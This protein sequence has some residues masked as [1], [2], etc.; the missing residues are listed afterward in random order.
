MYSTYDVMK[1]K[2]NRFTGAARIGACVYRFFLT[3]GHG[4]FAT[5]DKEKERRTATDKTQLHHNRLTAETKGNYC[6][7]FHDRI[8]LL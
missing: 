8:Q 6:E 2:N 4:T 5:T 1:G 3:Y 7:N